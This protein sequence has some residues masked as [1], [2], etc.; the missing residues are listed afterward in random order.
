MM[1]IQQAT[2]RNTGPDIVFV[3]YWK[4][5]TPVLLGPGLA[6]GAGRDIV[7]VGDDVYV[8]G[9]E[10][11]IGDLEVAKYWKNG[12]PVVLS[13]GGSCATVSAIDVIGEDVYVTGSEVD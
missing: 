9:T 3:S 7:V 5:N 6:G 13:D 2:I 4:N 1:F 8:A 12:N 11:N 10:N